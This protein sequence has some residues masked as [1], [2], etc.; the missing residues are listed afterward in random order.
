MA[1]L[2]LNENLVNEYLSYK[3]S[4]SFNQDTTRK[5][6]KYIHT[7][8]LKSDHPLMQDPSL[9]G[10]LDGGDPLIEIS[11]VLDD[12]LLVQNSRLKLMLIDKIIVPMPIFTTLNIL[13][14]S[15]KLKPKYGATYPNAN[16]K[17]KALSHIRA[18]LSDAIW[19]NVIDSY[20]ADDSSQWNTN[21]LILS[22][23]IPKKVTKLTITSG[24]QYRNNRGDIITK[25]NKINSD[26]QEELKTICGDWI[27]ISQQLNADITH[28]RYIETDKLKIL[29]SSGLYNLSESS[30]KD[31]TYII[32]IKP[33]K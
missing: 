3:F 2:V 26:E 21:K 29:L 5:L 7:F 6:L 24:S 10:Q 12:V 1:D 13:N 31:F 15:E 30:S 8:P 20:I 11:D 9:I 4:T 17:N 33:I 28:D 25:K 14:N 22:N 18:L 27:I 16:E 32:E 19:I 23:I